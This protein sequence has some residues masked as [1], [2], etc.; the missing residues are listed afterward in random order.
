MLKKAVVFIFVLFFLALPAYALEISG[1]ANYQDL[2]F[3][4]KVQSEGTRIDFKND[5]GI[6]ADEPVG[7]NLRLDAKRHHFCFDYVSIK[8][9]G[10]KWLSQSIDFQGQTYAADIYLESK[11]EYDLFEAQ[12]NFDLIDLKWANWGISLGPL[13]KVSVYD[14]SVNLS[15]GG[16]NESYAETLPLP[17]LG[18]VG[19][20][21]ATKY[22]SFL[23]Q[24]NGIGYS[25]NT[26]IEYKALLRLKPFKYF[27][28]DIGY[29]GMQVDYSDDNDLLDLEVKGF[30][31]QGNFIYKF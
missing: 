6:E 21:E 13:F 1:G 9:E 19:E 18:L 15:G 25:G 22:L 27:N 28:F 23:A 8:A 10:A 24:A 30:L 31:L 17:T 2:D 26:Y 5:L 29:K 16:F 11:L 3:S 12:Y 20:L 4:G 7:F 14:A